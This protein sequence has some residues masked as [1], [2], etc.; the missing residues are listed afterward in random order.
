MIKFLNIKTVITNLFNLAAR[1]F[2]HAAVQEISCV[3]NG[4]LVFKRLDLDI[5]WTDWSYSGKGFFTGI[6]CKSS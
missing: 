1:K 6:G 3:D 5:D 2:A 4:I